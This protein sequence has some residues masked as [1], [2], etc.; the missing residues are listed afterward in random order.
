MSETI[1]ISGYL[2]KTVRGKGIVKELNGLGKTIMQIPDSLHS[3]NEWCRD[4]MPVKATDDSFVLF[5]YCPAYLIGRSSYEKTIPDQLAICNHFSI[6]VVEN[7]VQD[8]I[9][10]GGAIEIY[11]KKAMI[12]DRV[13]HENNCTWQKGT[14]TIYNR[15]KLL[16]RLDELIVVPSDPW[17]FTGHVDGLVRFIND[18]E[19]LINDYSGMDQQIRNESKFVQEKYHLWKYNFEQTLSNAGLKA[20]SLTCTVHQNKSDKAATGV[21]MNFLKLDDKIIMPEFKD[22]D[23]N[24]KKAARI[25]K[26]A[27]ER[28]VIPVETTLLS[29]EGGIINCVTWTK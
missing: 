6:P 12:S 14:P 27:Y 25:L 3:G 24:N 17:D 1:Y 21:Y 29:E 8:I 10:D 20:I 23:E 4:Y 22:Q 9:M 26:S 15:I 18:S 19:V 28:E 7:K 2:K 16:L 5:K 13:F 11:G